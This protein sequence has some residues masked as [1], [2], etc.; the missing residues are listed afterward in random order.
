MTIHPN[1]PLSAEERALADQLARSAPGRLPP[2]AVDAAIL[3][4][5][6]AA[7]RPRATSRRPRWP[8]VAGIAATLVLAIGIAW[9]L[10][11]LSE[12]P[13]VQEEHAGGEAATQAPAPTVAMIE[14]DEPAASRREP[15]PAQPVSEPPPGFEAPPAEPPRADNS[16]RV[17]VLPTGQPPAIEPPASESPA[18]ALPAPVAPLSVPV[19]SPAPPAP[20]PAP[21]A[22]PVP[23]GASAPSTASA[24]HD[25]AR[26]QAAQ[27]KAV[28]QASRME[29]R[30]SAAPPPAPRVGAEDA[31]A[32]TS[33]TV[34]DLPPADDADL[35][36]D[37][38]IERIRQRRD[39]GDLEGARASLRL[40]RESH[41]EFS[42]PEDLHALD[43]GTAPT[44]R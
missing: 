43:D 36:A 3:H 12:A 25:A 41:P 31:V 23:T 26:Q 30:A 21:P 9:Q 8:A 15:G 28:E 44:A 1:D 37:V 6:H 19:P 34:V 7:S 39:A 16:G 10:R 35:A 14:P 38:W 42:L 11:P 17:F 32:R 2:P 18:V 20:P 4:A 40:L 22:P 24:A 33:V 29:R 13:D 27:R 5:A